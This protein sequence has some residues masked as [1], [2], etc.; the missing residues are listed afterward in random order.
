MQG[1]RNQD[2][3]GLRQDSERSRHTKFCCKNYCTIDIP[4]L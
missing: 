1:S 2:S 4:V 3:A